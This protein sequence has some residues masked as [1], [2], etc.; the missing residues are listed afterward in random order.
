[1]VTE[2][3]P[4]MLLE[5]LRKCWTGVIMKTVVDS[6]ESHGM[7]LDTQHAFR[8]SCGTYT[9][10]LQIKTAFDQSWQLWKKLYGSSTRMGVPPVIIDWVIEL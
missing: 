4:I 3:W 10:K 5:I 7:L 2:L 8:K 1:M 6:I 9:A